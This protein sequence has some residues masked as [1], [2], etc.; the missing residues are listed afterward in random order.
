MNLEPIT[1]FLSRKLASIPIGAYVFQWLL[2]I[3]IQAGVSPESAALYAGGFAGAVTIFYIGA[4]A[5]YD[6]VS[7]KSKGAKP[8][9]ETIAKAAVDAYGKVAAGQTLTAEQMIEAIKNAGL[10]SP[11]LPPPKPE[12]PS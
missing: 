9:L 12:K 6:V 7:L 2:P 1:K 10:M 3:L 8:D 5:Y 11:V 4:Q